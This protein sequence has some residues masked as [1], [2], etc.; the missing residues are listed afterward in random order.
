[1]TTPIIKIESLS[2]SYRKQDVPALRNISLE[3]FEGERVGLI[4]HNGSGKTT[5]MRCLLNFL[6]PDEGSISICGEKNL[7][8]AKQHI[9]FIPERQHGLENFTPNELLKFAAE[10]QG[11]TKYPALATRLSELKE[12][13][14][15]ASFENVL[16]GELS[17]GMF[18]R[19]QLCLA[20]LHQPPILLLDEPTSGLDPSGKRELLRTLHR[21]KGVTMLY[22][23]HHL[24]EI[25]QLC[26]KVVILHQGEVRHIIPESEL[27]KSH[28][29]ITL[30]T[31]G[32]NVL[33]DNFAINYQ[34]FDENA[35][36]IIVDIIAEDAE[37]QKFSSILQKQNIP[38]LRLRT[39]GY[40]EMLYEQYSD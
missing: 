16:I 34:I 32:R 5:L 17:K 12:L 38:I 24:E 25:E 3:I 14:E 18:Q 26:T 19:V 35:D 29:R 13:T 15:I 20:L 33:T 2:K 37:F 30:P 10:M 23:S 31:I 8:V 11:I 4:G 27:N 40:L 36:T 22:A 9:G 1:M 39:K 28:F 21:L 6:I 7:E